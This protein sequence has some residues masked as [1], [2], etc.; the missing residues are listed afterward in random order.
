M[1]EKLRY[2]LLDGIV[3]LSDETVLLEETFDALIIE[4]GIT[5]VIDFGPFK[6]GYQPNSLTLNFAD[7][8]MTEYCP[9]SCEILIRC[10]FGLFAA[11]E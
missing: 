2:A 9:D 4:G 7:G 8:T 6:R 5:F 10:K 1:R 11:A 3:E